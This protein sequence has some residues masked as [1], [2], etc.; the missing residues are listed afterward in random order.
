MKGIK[1]KSFEDLATRAHDMKLSMSSTGKDMTI[2]HDPRKGRDKQEPKR[3]SKFVPRNDNKESMSVN[4]SPSKFTTTEGINQ[5]VRTNLQ[6]HSNQKS[7]QREMQGKSIPSWIL[8]F[9]KFLMNCS[10]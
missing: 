5:N 1:P 8:T 3:W 10:I 2:V 6:A 4:M 7:T 9:L